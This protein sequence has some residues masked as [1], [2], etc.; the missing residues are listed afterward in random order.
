[1][2]IDLATFTAQAAAHNVTVEEWAAIVV[3]AY[4]DAVRERVEEQEAVA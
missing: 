2:T 4:I 1:M 3:Q